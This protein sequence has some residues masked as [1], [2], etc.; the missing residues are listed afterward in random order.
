MVVEL[1]DAD[2]AELFVRNANLHDS[3]DVDWYR[4]PVR[5]GNDF[6]NP[7]LTVELSGVPEGADYQLGAWFVCNDGGNDSNCQAGTVD[8]LL[9]NGCVSTA[10]GSADEQVRI[11]TG[12]SGIGN[13]EH[14]NLF[15]RVTSQTHSASCVNYVLRVAI[16]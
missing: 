3:G 6:G 1:N 13:F 11:S 4:F 9:G 8:N 15:V 14:G 5:D 16:R 12:C 10:A 7:K 2:D